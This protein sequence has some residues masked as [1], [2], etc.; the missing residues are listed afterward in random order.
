MRLKS[1]LEQWNTL[2]AIDEFGS[3]QAASI[4]LSKSHTTLIYLV[5]KLEEQLDI[6]LVEVVGR[7]AALTKDGKTLLRHANSM[8]EQAESLEAIST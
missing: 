7:K 1:T 6:K 8:L 3:I 5:K 2:R 4:H